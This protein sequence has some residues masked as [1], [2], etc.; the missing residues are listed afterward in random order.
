MF[1]DVCLD[2]FE[3]HKSD[4]KFNTSLC[5][6]E[7]RSSS[8]LRKSD[9]VTRYLVGTPQL[10]GTSRGRLARPFH[11]VRGTS[12]GQNLV[13][14]QPW[15]QMAPFAANEKVV[16]TRPNNAYHFFPNLAE[17]GKTWISTIITGQV[18][19]NSRLLGGKRKDARQL[20][21][22]GLHNTEIA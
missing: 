6:R 14:R 12:S 16:Q 13:S 10:V 4:S 3:L 5:W 19:A 20:S 22:S 18:G 21:L 1:D 11:L 7:S 9:E 2:Q 8:H 15:L 17:V